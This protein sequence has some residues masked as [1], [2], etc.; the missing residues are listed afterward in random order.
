[1][2]SRSRR[3]WK[4]YADIFKR[5]WGIDEQTS[6]FIGMASKNLFAAEFKE[7]GHDAYRTSLVLPIRN[8]YYA[9]QVTE[10]RWGYLKCMKLESP[11]FDYG[12]GVGFLL[13]WLKDVGFTDLH[14]YEVPGVQRDVLS[15]VSPEH[16][17]VINAPLPLNYVHTSICL[18]VLEH[19]EKPLLTLDFLKSHSKQVIA[20]VCLDREEA[21][22]VAPL[23]ELKECELLLRQWGTLYEDE[24]QAQDCC[25]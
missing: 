8:S 24:R 1:M 14:G 18:N 23:D 4:V 3:I 7:H 22:H 10:K 19:L 15:D 11:I 20:N 13:L 16:G 12:C 17:I 9:S 21:S 6:E 2:D 5:R 25:A